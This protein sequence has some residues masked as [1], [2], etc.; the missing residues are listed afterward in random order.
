MR[1]KKYEN[2]SSP[3]ERQPYIRNYQWRIMPQT[4]RKYKDY[5]LDSDIFSGDRV[6]TDEQGNIVT[7][8]T[9]NAAADF[10][11]QYRNPRFELDYPEITIEGNGK[12]YFT[13]ESFADRYARELAAPIAKNAD[14]DKTFK[15]QAQRQHEQSKEKH[16]ADVKA[17]DARANQLTPGAGTFV[18][19]P[20]ALTAAGI[21]GATLAPFLAPGTIGGNIIG[22]TAFG[23]ALNQAMKYGTGKTLG[24][25]AV[26]A[27]RYLGIPESQWGDFGIQMIG[28]LPFYVTGDLIGKQVANAGRTL[29]KEA[30]D[31]LALDNTFKGIPINPT[32]KD[33]S[34]A[35]STALDQNLPKTPKYTEYKLP[36]EIID[37]LVNGNLAR[38]N[39]SKEQIAELT[40][41]LK[42]TTYRTWNT[43]AGRKQ[44]G[45]NTLG[46]YLPKDLF[47]S[48]SINTIRQPR[49]AATELI[50]LRHE[51]DHLLNYGD[52]KDPKILKQ[53]LPEIGQ[54][55]RFTTIGDIRQ[56]VLMDKGKM[57]ADASEQT[58]LLKGI[59][60]KDLIHAIE[61]TSYGSDIPLENLTPD[62]LQIIREAISLPVN[63]SKPI[64]K[65]TVID[66]DSVTGQIARATDANGKIRLRLPSHTQE[67]PRE[68]VLVPH[69]NNQYELHI[70]T[71]DGDHVPANL[72]PQEKTALFESVYN[73]LPEGAEI[74][75]P[76]SSADYPATRGTVA[77]LT[78]L[79]R[80]PRFQRGNTTGTLI[81]A[82]K[83]GNL[84]TFTGNS[85]IKR[86]TKPAQIL[87]QQYPEQR[88]YFGYFGP[89]HS[90][91]EVVNPD[92]TVNV[93]KAMQIANRAAYE[94][95][96]IRLQD[97]LENPE[98]HKTDP[99]TF[100]HTKEV[101]QRAWQMPT[102]AG[103]TKQDQMFAALG[104][105]FGKMFAGE[106]HGEIGADYLRQVFPDMTDAQYNAIARHMMSEDV[107]RMQFSDQPLTLA[108]ME[109]DRGGAPL[110]R[111]LWNN[112]LTDT[113][114][115][116]EYLQAVQRGDIETAQ[117][118]RNEHFMSKAIENQLVTDSGEILPLYHFSDAHYNVIN[119]NKFGVNDPGFYGRGYYTTPDRNYGSTYGPIE[120]KYYGYSRRPFKTNNN[121]DRSLASFSFNRTDQSPLIDLDQLGVRQELEQADA[122]W[123]QGISA[124]R[125]D[126]PIEE[127]VFP[128]GYRLK[129]ADAVTYDDN[130]NIV[131]LS[132]RDD[133]NLNDTRYWKG[134]K[135]IPRK[136]K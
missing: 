6:W 96:G 14:V 90:I 115:D 57:M 122:S 87:Q 30:L 7:A 83:D 44:F 88:I 76:E 60:D 41:K 85:F 33:L 67:K 5:Y 29:T 53:A 62:R 49:D 65:N 103:Y 95:G 123:Q 113:S 81:Y 28:D 134:G 124:F 24:E 34:K 8:D 133:F 71:W 20:L 2:A 63:Y 78:H 126:K 98:W 52:V 31:Q 93:Q 61:R 130:G 118:L 100:L 104:H 70:R 3:I 105:D 11:V 27:A 77:A 92:G 136:Y 86:Q 21:G 9:P 1:I 102:P 101:A 82:D 91:N 25:H 38:A 110:F 135:L 125:D 22:T 84:Q 36:D 72:N 39:L 17:A 66:V 46:I 59:S 116:E 79:S 43:T 117:R 111:D 68:V 18:G 10:A 109:A 97:R 106:G 120:Y 26:N 107:A 99:N 4:E 112:H 37:I 132:K 47:H 55:E 127:I 40:N 16:D 51:F 13:G 108:T 32:T 54:N 128:D 35:M 131:P 64:N 15:E 121:E 42:N 56:R 75:F 73:E 80:D 19:I 89:K 50:T 114:L 74:L 58:E 23:E 45:D 119:P 69:G 12:G 129:L 94:H 48:E